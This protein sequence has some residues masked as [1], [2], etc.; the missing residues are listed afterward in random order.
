MNSNN[1]MFND[2][3]NFVVLYTNNLDETKKFYNSIEAYLVE[4]EDNKVVYKLGGNEIH[5]VNSQYQTNLSYAYNNI[6][7][8]G[9][10]VLFYIGTGN[11]KKT[12]K[13]IASIKPKNMT[14]IKDNNWES[15]E[16]LFEDNNGY[17]F[18]C[19]EDLFEI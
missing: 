13:K 3:S 16:F 7:I 19:Y 9:Q 12:F 4:E 8:I 6:G 11:I 2:D 1:H 15:K 14:D 17:K 10:G 5:F 18:V